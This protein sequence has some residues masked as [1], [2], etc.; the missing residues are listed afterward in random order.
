[1][2]R[3]NGFIADKLSIFE[4]Q[5]PAGI[6]ICNNKIFLVI[7]KLRRSFIIVDYGMV[8]TAYVVECLKVWEFAQIVKSIQTFVGQ[9]LMSP[10]NQSDKN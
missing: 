8:C 5:K 1:M 10:T 4:L 7:R 9:N 2:S 6:R 3:S